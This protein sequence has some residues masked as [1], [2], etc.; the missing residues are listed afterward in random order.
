L[1]GLNWRTLNPL[2]MESAALNGALGS[3]MIYS[4]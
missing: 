1:A 3:G 4:G 2:M